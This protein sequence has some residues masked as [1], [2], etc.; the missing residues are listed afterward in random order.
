MLKPSLAKYIFKCTY[1][2][3]CHNTCIYVE[4]K[5]LNFKPTSEKPQEGFIPPHFTFE[6]FASVLADL[7]EF[8]LNENCISA[9]EQYVR[10]LLHDINVIAWRYGN[11]AASYK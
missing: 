9:E 3:T 1:D 6:V 5:L 10:E 2:A 7:T 11:A 8:L 4:R